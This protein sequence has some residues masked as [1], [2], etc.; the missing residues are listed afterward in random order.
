[1]KYDIR[2]LPVV[3]E[4][5][6]MGYQ[7][8]ESK[9]PGLGDEFLR[10]FYACLDEIGRNPLVSPTVHQEIPRAFLRRFP[11]AVYFKVQDREAIVVGVFHCARDP[12][13]LETI[14][15]ERGGPESD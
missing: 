8:Y 3:E 2:F 14:L 11:Y 4:D 6:V 15:V 9:V 13:K 1:M 12:H 10:T 7:W 5:V